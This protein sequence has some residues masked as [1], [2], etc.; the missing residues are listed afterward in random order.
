MKPITNLLNEVEFNKLTRNQKRV[1]IAED[2]IFRIFAENLIESNGSILGGNIKEIVEEVPLKEA[3]NNTSCEV[4][5][6]GAIMC[7]WIGNFN[8]VTWNDIDPLYRRMIDYSSKGFPPQLLEVFDQEMLDNIE[9]AFEH[10]TFEWHYDHNETQK[11]VDAFERYDDEE[12]EYIGT[13][14]V[15]LMEWIIKNNGDFPLP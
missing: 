9:A 14:I 8:K 4:C 2:V 3:I 7:S 6:R 5:A 10:S 11:Y 1:K 13:P 12:D 15:L